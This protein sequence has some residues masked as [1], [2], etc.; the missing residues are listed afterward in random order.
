M[1]RE[2]IFFLFENTQFKEIENVYSF[3]FYFEFFSVCFP[4]FSCFLFLDKNKIHLDTDRYV[5]N[6]NKNKDF[7]CQEYCIKIQLNVLLLI[8]KVAVLNSLHSKSCIMLNILKMVENT[9]GQKRDVLITKLSK[10]KIKKGN[11]H[12]TEKLGLLLIYIFKNKH[13]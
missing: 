5:Y 13:K 9:V 1:Q 8:R 12:S 7:L 10:Q 6:K 3:K 11:I 4:L 2:V